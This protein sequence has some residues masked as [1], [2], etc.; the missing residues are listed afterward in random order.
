MSAEIAKLTG[1]RPKRKRKFGCREL[2]AGQALSLTAV[3]RADCHDALI[4]LRRKAP[5][6]S[7]TAF[8]ERFGNQE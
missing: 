1:L 8:V 4:L 5:G 6:M 2:N 3:E 7:L